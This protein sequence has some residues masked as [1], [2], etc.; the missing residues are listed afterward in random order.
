MESIFPRNILAFYHTN[1]DKFWGIQNK[2]QSEQKE[3]SLGITSNKTKIDHFNFFYC[4]SFSKLHIQQLP[5]G[6][7]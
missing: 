3:D 1:D 2:V 6:Y 4:H 7:K 5:K